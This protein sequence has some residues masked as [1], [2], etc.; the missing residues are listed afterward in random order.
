MG[1]AHQVLLEAKNSIPGL[2]TVAF[3]DGMEC[4]PNTAQLRSVG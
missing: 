3:G 2:R 4:P 1:Q